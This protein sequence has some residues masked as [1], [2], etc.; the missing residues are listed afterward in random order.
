MQQLI[1]EIVKGHENPMPRT[2]NKGKEN[3][4]VVYDQK[5]YAHFGGAFPQ[6]FRLSHDDHNNAYPVGKYT[7]ALE[8]FG[9]GRWGDLEINGRQMKLVPASQELL[10]AV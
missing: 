8:S 7:L 2:V 6:E 4:R 9:I 5:A 1:I 10:K 3:E